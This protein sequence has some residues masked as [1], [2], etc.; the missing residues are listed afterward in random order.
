MMHCKIA[1]L[2]EGF[3]FANVIFHKCDNHTRRIEKGVP[4]IK[5]NVIVTMK[6][7]NSSNTRKG[8]S[9]ASHKAIMKQIVENERSPPESDLVSLD[10]VPFACSTFT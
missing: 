7:S 1:S 3:S 2:Q 6:T 10:A 9:I 8:D 5:T 4:K